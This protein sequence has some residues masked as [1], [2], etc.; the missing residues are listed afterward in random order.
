MTVPRK[1]VSA[2]IAC[3]RDAP[4]VPHMYQRLRAVFDLVGVDGEIIF[5]N[6]ASPDD[7]AEVLRELASRDRSV[8]V[9]NHTRN[10]VSQTAFTSG[11]RIASGHAVVLIAVDLPD[12]PPRT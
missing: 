2:I 4:A 9:I 8:V 6:D 5:V 7:A 12:P 11:M 10:F 1:K 3:Y